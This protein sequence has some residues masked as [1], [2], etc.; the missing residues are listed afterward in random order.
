MAEVPKDSPQVRAVSSLPTAQPVSQ[1]ASTPAS[2]PLCG[3]ARLNDVNKLGHSLGALSNIG[4]PAPTRTAPPAD[5]GKMFGDQSYVK[6]GRDSQLVGLMKQASNN[7]PALSGVA[8]AA[9]RGSIR[10]EDVRALQRELKS[11]GF[12]VGHK[13]AD[14]KY[15]PE[16]HKALQAMLAAG[17]KPT[18]GPASQPAS[19]PIS[20]P[21]SQPTGGPM[22]GIGNTKDGLTIP[23]GQG[24][25]T[26]FAN[27]HIAYKGWMDKDNRQNGGIG[28]WGDKN[29]P[30]DYFVAL[31]VKDKK[32][33]NQ[34]ILI[35]D[36]KTGKQVVALVQDKGP[37]ARTG[38]KIDLS[39]VTMEALG[40]DFKRQGSTQ[41]RFEFAPPDAKVGP[42]N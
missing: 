39:P 10:Q 42:V 2:V 31:P 35:T 37:A 15:G 20:R 40:Y 34:K 9:A 32:W 16:T 1:P 4:L 17:G 24:K 14:G 7:N 38:A 30:T 5:Y 29:A 25:A 26:V 11:K 33:H 6:N 18:A 21:T 22:Q 3:A 13:G 36:Q 19:Q 41:V 28:A 12:D 8:E 23:A 27:G